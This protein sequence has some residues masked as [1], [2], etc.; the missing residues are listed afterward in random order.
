[1]NHFC[2]FITILVNCL[3]SQNYFNVRAQQE[4]LSIIINYDMSG[5]L[6]NGDEV[7][8]ITVNG[9]WMNLKTR[10]IESPPKE[11]TDKLSLMQ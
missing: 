10:K 9:A 8:K 11:M 4:G 2:I 1:M 5:K 7:A 6:E 3:W